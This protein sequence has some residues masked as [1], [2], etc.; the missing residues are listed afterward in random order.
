MP[1]TSAYASSRAIGTTEYTAF[2]A[3]PSGLGY[4]RVRVSRPEGDTTLTAMDRAAPPPP[5][6][7]LEA[8]MRIG[9]FVIERRIGAGGMG[10][11]Y[12]A[13][14]TELARHVA[15]KLVRPRG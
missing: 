13:R 6:V 11:V 10:V 2:Q 12:A 5:V 14:D 1:I 7:E 9:R 4:S 3:S 15:L 8:G